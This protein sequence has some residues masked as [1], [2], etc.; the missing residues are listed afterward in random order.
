MQQYRVKL[1]TVL[2]H[3]ERY[4]AEGNPLRGDGFLEVSGQSPDQISAV[5]KQFDAKGTDFLQPVFKALNGEVGYEELKLLRL[6]FLNDRRD[7]NKEP[8]FS[9]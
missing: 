7:L 8:D 1:G 3:L 4:A 2:G 5:I 6:Y 9:A